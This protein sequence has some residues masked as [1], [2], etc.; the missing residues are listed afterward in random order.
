MPA[1]SSATGIVALLGLVTTLTL[2]AAAAP[3]RDG[4]EQSARPAT[5]LEELLETMRS[6]EAQARRDAFLVLDQMGTAAVATLVALLEVDD[7][8]VRREAMNRLTRMVH[9]GGL[10]PAFVV[11]PLLQ[12]LLTSE[13]VSTRTAVARTLAGLGPGAQE[14]TPL[15]IQVVDGRDPAEDQRSLRR[16]AA[17]ALVQVDEHA[18]SVPALMRALED[19]NPAA[20]PALWQLDPSAAQRALD[21]AARTGDVWTCA[22]L[23]PV[24]SRGSP[25][26]VAEA[27]GLPG[28]R[29]HAV[30][31]LG[32]SEDPAA[33][34]PLER[35]LSDPDASV[36]K[37]AV[38]GLRELMRLEDAGRA[39]EARRALPALAAVLG[40][41]D[42]EVRAAAVTAL[43]SIGPVPGLVVP[44]LAGLLE[45]PDAEVRRKAAEAIG[46]AGL[47]GRSAGPALVRAAVDPDRDVR[48]AVAKALRDVKWGVSEGQLA[49]ERTLLRVALLALVDEGPHRP[50]CLCVGLRQPGGLVEEAGGDVM[51]ALRTRGIKP[52]AQSECTT[53][54]RSV[55]CLAGL[56]GGPITWRSKD[57]AEVEVGMGVVFEGG[58]HGLMTLT[59]VGSE[60]VVTDRE[61]ERT[62][63]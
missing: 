3:A 5:P 45:D 6:G 43:A 29:L 57:V 63:E 35:A 50:R 56:W 31:W 16:S 21:Q 49:Q 51:R 33:R 26:V 30:H 44:P 40:D 52:I 34:K 23:V 18:D 17:E 25:R 9:A 10:R 46:A 8:N 7:W 28:C 41:S 59:R 61:L 13:S 36:R 4:D 14:A 12:L 55:Q 39:R 42:E 58:A 62:L 27:L 2:P 47:A 15:L 20:A 24:G 48:D 1:R 32:E 11:T 19:R 54:G 53:K 38:A 37:E 60:W 22:A